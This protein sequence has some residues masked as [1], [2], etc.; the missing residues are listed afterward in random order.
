[1]SWRENPCKYWEYIQNIQN[2]A[3]TVTRTQDQTREPGAV[4]W[5]FTTTNSNYI[6]QQSS[7]QSYNLLT[8]FHT[9]EMYDVLK[10]YIYIL[11]ASLVLTLHSHKYQKRSSIKLKRK[12]VQVCSVY[13]LFLIVQI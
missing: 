4:K 9:V 5:Q 7:I 6:L 2:S 3:Q 12:S 8:I 10:I 1:M 11:H 13:Q